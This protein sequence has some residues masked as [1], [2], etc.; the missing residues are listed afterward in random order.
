MC[1]TFGKNKGWRVFSG[2]GVGDTLQRKIGTF[3]T[4][5]YLAT[6]NVFH[7]PVKTPFSFYLCKTKSDYLPLHTFLIDIKRRFN[8]E[9]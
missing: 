6:V 3:W 1:I 4:L 9:T 2:L 8:E 7:Q 5:D